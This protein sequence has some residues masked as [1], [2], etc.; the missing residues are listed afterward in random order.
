MTP[1]GQD[2]AGLAQGYG[3]GGGSSEKGGLGNQ[4]AGAGN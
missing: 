4:E 2:G 3:E 1:V